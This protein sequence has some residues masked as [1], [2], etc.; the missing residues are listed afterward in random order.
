VID[1]E[2]NIKQTTPSKS[3]SSLKAP[4]LFAFR[5]I[6]SHVQKILPYFQ[7]LSASLQKAALKI[8]L[9]SYVS[10]IIVI[11]G[12]SFVASFAATLILAVILVTPILLALL[13]A[14]GTSFLVGALVF[15]AMY[16]LPALLASSRR[17]KMDLELPYVASHMSILAAAGV[18][19]ARIFK[20]MLDSSTT[21]EVASESNEITRDVEILGNDI[22]TAIEAERKR[23]PSRHFAE[24]L[25][26]M[27]ATIRSGGDL[28]N[29]LLDTTHAM[30]DLRRIAAKQLVES[31]ASFA[32]VY[33]V[34][35]VVFPLLIIVM[36][37]VMA[38]IGGGLA[39]MSVSMLMMFVTYLVIPLCGF[40]VVVMLD[41]L[42]VED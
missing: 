6:G 34:L 20:L 15:G 7:D 16:A 11:S 18:Y 3:L 39:G 9:Q 17:K 30:M 2:K 29:F 31:L 40:A 23:S 37:S 24:F 41:N 28:K 26:G 35:L 4:W 32:E 13:F 38:L 27:V 42:L 5:H 22:I 25:E 33:V 8:S 36:F 19:P 10:M 12:V 14:V 1:L 21:P